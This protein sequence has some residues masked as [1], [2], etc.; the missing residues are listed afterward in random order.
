MSRCSL[1]LC[2]L[3]CFAP[4]VAR[5]EGS[6]ELDL[7]DSPT[8]EA[9]DQAF[10]ADTLLY[11]DILDGANEK[12]CYRGNNTNLD[13]YRPSPNSGTLVAS[14]VTGACTDAVAGVNGAYLIDIGS[15]NIGVAWDVRV[16]PRT[17]SDVACLTEPARELR[18]RLYSYDWSF[19]ANAQYIDARSINGSV[20][21]VVPGGA[22]GRDAVIEMQMRGVSGARYHLRANG[23]GP[24]TSG[25]TRIGRSAPIAGNRVTPEY[26]LYLSPPAIAKYDWLAPQIEQVSI[27]P[28]CGSKL[29]VERAPGSIQFRSNLVGQYVLICDVSG[30]G[31]YDLAADADFSSFGTTLLGA[32]QV[33]W[34]G[35]TKGGTDAAPGT[36]DCVVRLNV[37]EFHYIAEDIESAFPGI[38][39]FRLEADRVTRTPLALFWDD[40]LVPV[41]PEAMPNGRRSPTAPSALG[42]DPGAYALASEPYSA[43]GVARVGNARAWGNF[44]AD[45]KGNDNF[46]DQFSS[47]A[48][49]ESTPFQI[50]V[51]ARDVDQD[52]DGLQDARECEL[53]SDPLN[54]DSDGDH[55][56]DGAEASATS[57]PDTDGD[58]RPDV[59]DSDDDGDGRSTQSE[60][61]PRENGDG[62]PADALDTDRDGQKDYLDVDADDDG[63]GDA[64]DSAPLDPSSCRDLDADGCDD[65]SVTR[66]DRSGGNAAQD[67]PDTDGDGICDATDKDNAADAGVRADA[68]VPEDAGARVDAGGSGE[69]AGVRDD[70]GMQPTAAE[71][72]SDDD[73]IPDPMEQPGGQPVDTDRDGAPNAMDPDDDGDRVPTRDERPDGRD[74][75]TDGDGTPN[76]LDPDDDGDTISTPNEL[77][78]VNG[79]GVPDYLQRSRGSLAGGALCTVQAP[80]SRSA[81][82]AWWIALSLLWVRRRKHR[83]TARL[84]LV[85]LLSA[86]SSQLQ[87]QVAL[88]PFKPAPLASDGFALSRPD[89]LP[90]LAPGAL[91]LLDYANDPLVY[92][93]SGSKQQE[94][95]VSQHLQ[96]HA[97]VALG[98][99]DRL[100]VFGQLPVHLLMSGPDR[101]MAPV[102][103]ADG[104]GL[105]DLALGGRLCVIGERDS[106]FALSAE[107]I[108]RLPTAELAR[109]SQ[110]YSGD[111]IGS[112]E[113]AL[114]AEL[115]MGQLALRA[116]AAAR[117][118]KRSEVGNLALEHELVYG[119]GA[120]YRVLE[121][122]HAHAELYGSTFLDDPWQR[123]HAP[124]ELLL[125]LKAV[126]NAWNIGLAAGPGLSHG[127]GAPDVRIVGMAGYAPPPRAITPVAVVLDRDHD[128][129]PDPKDVCVLEPEDRDGVDDADGC[130]D[131]DNDRDG[132]LDDADKCPMNPEDREG[133]EDADGCPDPDN[134]ADTI[135]DPADKCPNDAEDRDG[136][137]DADG[138]AEPD[139][140]RDGIL[141]VKD[142][143]PVEKEDFDGFEDDDGCP[144]EGS[145]LVQLTCEKI[146]IKEAVYFDTGSDRIQDRSFSLLNQVAGVLQNASYVKHVRIEGHTDDRGKP[147]YNLDLSKR[148][149]ASVLQYLTA[150]DVGAGKLESQGY[151]LE[152]P[153]ADNKTD[154]GRGRNRRV[155]F[156]VTEQDA[157]GCK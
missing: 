64:D 152:K 35:K 25:G 18:G 144:E 108:A 46:L 127:F 142:K 129:L 132:V 105:G 12:V 14:L 55:V 92:E 81:A 4:H 29:I 122:L 6:A 80:G 31:V 91:L 140:D 94:R 16:C 75:D 148:R 95:V 21:A 20:Y 101:P 79:D 28:S 141:D 41:D 86:G 147:D 37:G 42:L 78:D 113:P 39:M 47:A 26:P 93:L 24:E 15:Q 156:V 135:L 13:V 69:D 44:N 50:S 112:Y 117:L 27:T 99:W 34:D 109:S 63:V 54:R 153:I 57:A 56:N 59:L 90:H 52:A 134:D 98:L 136:Y 45:G 30:D 139:N 3:L 11:V 19:Q 32:N 103:S 146:E 7:T 96:L 124:L 76:H 62:N 154:A 36:Y 70:A 68:G 118:R 61:G 143:C 82:S 66:S 71:H 107:L 40:T 121:A 149:A 60:L 123:V 74:I 87:A 10:D 115:R 33:R 155:E 100:V 126:L 23:R 89:V 114:I 77:Q 5:A 67:G 119:V 97:A 85:L 49:T 131:P 2:A 22:V 72:D 17:A 38:R 48:S 102:P 104:A 83:C 43:D 88:S 58:G 111:A 9:H 51:V 53:G 1:L 116:R 84:L 128:G 150:H 120:R 138:C 73:G 65:C 125:G 157:V 110:S 151:G 133:F 130:P 145:G 106:V 8:N 137:E